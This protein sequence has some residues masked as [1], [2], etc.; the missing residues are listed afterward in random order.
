M[1]FE[2]GV[3]V[4][5]FADD[6]SVETEPIYSAFSG[7]FARGVHHI[8]S[9]VPNSPYY[10]YI[11]ADENHHVT[12]EWRQSFA[13]AVHLKFGQSG[14]TEQAAPLIVRKGKPDKAQEAPEE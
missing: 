1:E 6:G 10:Y 4:G 3:N 9:R 2:I 11:L 5:K 14:A 12:D 7:L 8:R 13:D